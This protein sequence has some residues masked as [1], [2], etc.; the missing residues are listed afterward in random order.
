MHISAY[1][2]TKQTPTSSETFALRAAGAS[3][4]N[5]HIDRQA[6]MCTAHNRTNTHNTH[7]YKELY[8]HA[9]VCSLSFVTSLVPQ[10][11]FLHSL[12]NP[13]SVN[14]VNQLSAT[15]FLFPTPRRNT[16]GPVRVA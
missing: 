16:L 4:T 2:Y 13:G 10:K 12:Y 9:D 1:T 14:H 3:E 11:V 7:C 15:Y 6:L 5:T 8:T